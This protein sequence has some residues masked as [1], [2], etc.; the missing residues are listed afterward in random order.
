MSINLDLVI[1]TE[2]DTVDMK[3]ALDS[4][5]GVSDAVRYAAEGILTEKAPKRLSHKS[6]VRTSLKKVSK[7]LTGIFL[8]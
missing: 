2:E 4:M 3:A 1:E 5:Q 7:G 8:A 6:N